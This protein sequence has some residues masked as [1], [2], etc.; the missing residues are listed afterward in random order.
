M[1]VSA[2]LRVWSPKADLPTS[3]SGHVLVKWNNLNASILA[4]GG[5]DANGACVQQMDLYDI[6]TD[7][8]DSVKDSNNQDLLLPD[9]R[10]D[11]CAENYEDRIYIIGGR[12]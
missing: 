4:L 1:D 2:G 10:L 6:A 8:W 11:F 3:R 12:E 7:S 5:K 9:E